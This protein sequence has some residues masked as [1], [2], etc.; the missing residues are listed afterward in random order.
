LAFHVTILGTSSMVPTRHRGAPAVLVEAAGE[1]ILVDCGEGTQRQMNIAGKS[2]ARI[3]KILLTHWHGDHVGG[4]APLLQTI[5]T[6]PYEGTLE[7]YG[8]RGTRE[9]LGHLSCAME[10]ALERIRVTELEPPPE[11]VQVFVTNHAY[12]LSCAAMRHGVLTVAY[13]IEEHGRRR[14][15]MAK[16]AGFGLT[17]GPLVGHLQRGEPV[18]FDGKVIRPED[19]TYWHPGRKLALVTDTTPA[20][21]IVALARGADVLICES[22]YGS[23]HT[24]LAS[25]YNHMTARQVAELAREASVSRLV[26]THFSQRYDDV[27]PLLVEAREVFPETIAAEDFMTLSV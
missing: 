16:A 27:A 22:T 7:L 14:V 13:A 25:A 8:P 24:D 11:S 21:E 12:S 5:F 23:G 1:L 2:R 19:V 10:I 3:R 9:R 20:P 18:E 4:L 17:P 26:L 15:D 6:M